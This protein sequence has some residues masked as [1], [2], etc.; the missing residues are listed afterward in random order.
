MDYKQ[1]FGQLDPKL[2][3]VYERVMGTS[4]ASSPQASPVPPKLVMPTPV[5]S[6]PQPESP[7]PQMPQVP[8]APQIQTQA[9]SVKPH[10]HISPMVWILGGFT[11]VII[12]ALAWVKIFNFKLPFAP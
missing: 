9:I 4:V 6:I 8:T 1:Q 12:Y 7:K 10:G 3:E 2:K 5:A 11:F